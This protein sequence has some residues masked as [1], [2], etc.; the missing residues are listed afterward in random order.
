MRLLT[1]NIRHGGGD[2]TS[3]IAHVLVQKTPDVIALNEFRIPR[4][5][6]LR[7]ILRHNGWEHQAITSAADKMN[8]VLV[9]ARMPFET[10]T[11]EAVPELCRNRW[12]EASFRDANIKILAVHIPT[13]SN[14]D[15]HKEQ[16]WQAILERAARLQETST[17]A[18]VVGDLNTGK[19]RVDETGATLRCADCF[20]QM[21][22]AGWVDAM[23]FTEPNRS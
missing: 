19:H 21:E 14:A 4:G 11:D 17:H 15:H 18:V 6:R 8:G 20:E 3:D 16:F 7:N 23:A 9:A 5:Q 13:F 12:L 22:R 1:W 10:A 2:R